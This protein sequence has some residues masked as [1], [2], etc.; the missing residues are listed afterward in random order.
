MVAASK[1]AAH[2]LSVQKIQKEEAKVPIPALLNPRTFS[3]ILLTNLNHKQGQ[4]AAWK[5]RRNLIK[6]KVADVS[7]HKQRHEAVFVLANTSS[8]LT[9]GQLTRENG[10]GARKELCKLFL[11]QEGR[12]AATIVYSQTLP[13]RLKV[14]LVKVYGTET[15]ALPDFGAVP[16]VMSSDMA[17]LLSSVPEPTFT[18]IDVV[19]GQKFTCREA[20][21]VSSLCMEE[22]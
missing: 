15:S 2:G 19:I 12:K 13:G 1:R 21:K 5:S 17:E 14:A 16:N 7:D 10:E 3:K 20:L 11:Y 8:S 18:K 9:Y 6:S 22:E 4:N